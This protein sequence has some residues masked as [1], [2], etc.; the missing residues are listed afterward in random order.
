MS[1]ASAIDLGYAEFCAKIPMPWGRFN[2]SNTV[3]NA[4]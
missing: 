1:G 4:R 2:E 3:H